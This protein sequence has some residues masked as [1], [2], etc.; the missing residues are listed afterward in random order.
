MRDE[1]RSKKVRKNMRNLSVFS[2][3]NVGMHLFKISIGSVSSAI[4][5]RDLSYHTNTHKSETGQC[6]TE[7]E[8]L[9]LHLKI[10][11]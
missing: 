5:P 3:Q 9:Y 1:K 11:Y 8:N 4:C 7:L 6:I 10:P 2:K